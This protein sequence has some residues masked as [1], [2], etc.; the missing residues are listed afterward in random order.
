MIPHPDTLPDSVKSLV[1]KVFPASVRRKG[2]QLLHDAS[3]FN[4]FWTPS[5]RANSSRL[6]ALKGRHRGETCVIMGNGPSLAGTDFSLLKGIPT[7]GLNRG[8]MLWLEHD[9]TPM[10]FVAVNDLIVQ[11]F[12]EDIAELRCLKIIPWRW[13]R[14]FDASHDYLFLPQSWK[15]HFATDPRSG[16]WSGGTVTFTAMQI[17]YYMEFSKVVLIGVDHHYD[18]RGKPNEEVIAEG[19][20]PNHFDPAYFGKGIRWNLPDLEL[21]EIA[22][23]MARRVFADAGGEIVNATEQTALEI[24]ERQDLREALQR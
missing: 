8:Y 5:F 12:H 10:Y 7:F 15:P 4:A 14:L 16:V 21:S 3:E 13:R 17:A 20:D 11:Q 6:A 19:S 24:F 1:R 9:L 18:F 2:A 22:Y 23:E